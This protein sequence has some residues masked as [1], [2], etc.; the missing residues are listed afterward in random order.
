MMQ[1]TVGQESHVRHRS[2]EKMR[3]EKAPKRKHFPEVVVSRRKDTRR[4]RTNDL[5]H[6]REETLFEVYALFGAQRKVTNG[7]HKQIQRKEEQKL[8]NVSL[9]V[10]IA[11]PW[12][13]N[14]T[15]KGLLNSE[16]YVP[17]QDD[18]ANQREA[19]K[20]SLYVACAK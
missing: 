20:C 13:A 6:E 9:H 11:I 12:R 2:V 19:H 7:Q 16:E 10:L 5:L 14:T 18:V 3:E 1:Y 15:Y 8:A 17:M 4:R